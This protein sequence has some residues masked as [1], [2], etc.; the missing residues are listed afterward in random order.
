VATD[1]TLR[2]TNF[3]LVHGGWPFPRHT[4]S[5]FGKPNVYA[6]ISFLGSVN[7]P[8]IT[9]GVIREW[10]TFFPEKVLFGSDAYPDTPELGWE[11]WGWLGATG[12]RKALAMALTAMMQDGDITR[13]RAEE[14]AR[15]VLRENAAQLYKIGSQP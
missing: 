14:V 11:E 3:L 10:L 15:M 9:A 7:S 13:E 4:L 12:A 5:L 8:A 6:D 2:G 1:P